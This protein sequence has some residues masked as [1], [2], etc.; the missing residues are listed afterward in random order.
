[1][2]AATPRARFGKHRA[3]GTRGWARGTRGWGR[4]TQGWGRG[5]RG[6]GWEHGAWFGVGSAV[7]LLGVINMVVLHKQPSAGF[8]T[9]HLVFSENSSLHTLLSCLFFFV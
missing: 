7:A 3:R 9:K 1:M 2:K 4:G 5:T 8:G 6:S